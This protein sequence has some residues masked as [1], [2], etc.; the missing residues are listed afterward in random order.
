MFTS[1]IYKLSPITIQNIL[2]SCRGYIRKKLRENNSQQ[3]VLDEIKR[4]EFDPF[5]LSDFS[6]VML[7]KTLENAKEM[8]PFYNQ[9]ENIDSDNIKSFPLISKTNLLDNPE[10]FLNADYNGTIINGATSGTTGTPLTIKQNMT[11]IIR[12]QAF[13]ARHL[14]W[15]G[16]KQGDKR[17]WIRGDMIVPLKQRIAFIWCTKTSCTY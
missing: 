7:K 4:N 15:A 3:I 6:K 5:I 13:I 1:Q 2:L 9:I 11:S 14:E 17:A 16:F 10:I 8:I 12:E